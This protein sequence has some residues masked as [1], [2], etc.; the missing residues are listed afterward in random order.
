VIV[1]TDEEL[2]AIALAAEPEPAIPDDAVPLWDLL[3]VEEP[4][5]SAWYMPAPA[6][7][8]R[9]TGWRRNLVIFL[10]VVFLLIEAYGLC[11]AYGVVVLG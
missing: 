6:R 2:S 11:S 10:V 9:L 8:F 5:V 1:I 4:L 3:A 7:S